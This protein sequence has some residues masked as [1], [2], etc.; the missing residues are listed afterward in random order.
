MVNVYLLTLG[1]AISLG[2][3]ATIAL[4]AMSHTAR[5]HG[6]F[7]TAR[8]IEERPRW[9]GAIILFAFAITPFLASMLSTRAAEIF[10][11][12]SGNFLA[13]LAACALIFAVGFLD[14]LRLLHWR[15]KLLAQIAAASAVYAAGYRIDTLGLPW[16]PEIN[17]GIVAPVATV[18]WVVFFTNAINLIDGRDGV[19]AGAATLAA[20]T[21]AAIAADA[22]HPTVA[23][24]LV[25]VVGGTLGMLLFNLPP[26]SVFLGDSGALLLGFILGA[27][28]IRGATG[29]T[30]A[31]FIAVPIIALG[32]PIL[33]TVL[34]GVRRT[35][36]GRH[37]LIGD[38]D[39]IHHRLELAGFGP[40]GLLVVVY[41]I[42][43]MFA[44]G[45][46]LLHSVHFFGLELIVL[47][48]TLLLIAVILSRLGY[49]LM[50]WNSSGTIWLRRRLRGVRPEEA[51]AGR[52]VDQDS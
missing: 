1:L 52:L 20:I 6:L 7:H 18:L 33:D 8:G 21:L 9:G 23:L 29:A 12:K 25:A 44:A 43:A 40:R 37:P 35:L 14:D 48:S 16:G 26:A 11:P 3:I 45:A 30:D 31:V 10:E 49:M 50:L 41:G 17:M 22:H 24:L 34:A 19:A 51:E 47:L 28:S 46:L 36:Q 5:F 27:L 2:F 15:P 32:F 42:S 39:H 13:F 38:Q 4:L